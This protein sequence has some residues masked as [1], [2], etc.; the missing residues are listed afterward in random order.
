[1]ALWSVFVVVTDQASAVSR[2]WVA[3]E[4]EAEASEK[5]TRDSRRETGSVLLVSDT[6][7]RTCQ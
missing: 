6:I 4:G 1:M 3:A 7:R 5:A 2:K